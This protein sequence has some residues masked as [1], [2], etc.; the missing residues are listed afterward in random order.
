MVFTPINWSMCA[1][2]LAFL[3]FYAMPLLWI[4]LKVHI[5]FDPFQR[6]ILILFFLQLLCKFTLISN[7]TLA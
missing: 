3:A 4:K 2:N 7:Y 6:V 1:M 5:N